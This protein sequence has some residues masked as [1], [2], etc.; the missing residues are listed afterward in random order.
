MPILGLYGNVKTD[1]FN[2]NKLLIMYKFEKLSMYLK[3]Y[4]SEVDRVYHDNELFKF[5][6][7]FLKNSALNYVSSLNS[8]NI[9]RISDLLDRKEIFNHI[10]YNNKI[11]L[12]ICIS[13]SEFDFH[14]DF[15]YNVKTDLFNQNKLFIMYNLEKLSMYPKHRH[16]TMPSTVL[17][18]ENYIRL[19]GVSD[20]PGR[21]SGSEVFSKYSGFY[22]G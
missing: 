5:T 1:L 12:K 11:K 3:R 18:F 19:F 7:F 10:N 8:T 4:L 21:I 17:N 16:F 14:Y 22:Y 9:Q 20:C 15:Q 6:N 2:Q 13:I